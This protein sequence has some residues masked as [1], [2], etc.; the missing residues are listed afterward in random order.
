MP[1]PPFD[2]RAARLAAQ[3]ESLEEKEAFEKQ[4][5]KIKFHGYV[6]MSGPMFEERSPIL[7]K[8]LVPGAVK[9]T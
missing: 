8:A 6:G 5:P 1:T 2:Y 4:N 3:A 7:I 9:H